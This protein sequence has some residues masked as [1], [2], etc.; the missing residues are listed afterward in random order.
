MSGHSDVTQFD[1]DLQ[2]AIAASHAGHH[3][4][5]RCLFD[6][7]LGALADDQIDL[8]EGRLVEEVLTV[9]LSDAVSRAVLAVYRTTPLGLRAEAVLATMQR[10]QELSSLAPAPLRLL[11]ETSPEPLPD[12]DR[13]LRLWIARLER[14]PLAADAWR[15]PCEA[16]LHEA[17]AYERGISGLAE[18]ARSTQRSTAFQSW[19]ALAIEA[20][21]WRTVLRIDEEAIASLSDPRECAVLADHAALA[22]LRLGH[23]DIATRLQVAFERDPDLPRAL[24]W[25]AAEVDGRPP[26]RRI[27]QARAQRALLH[28]PDHAAALRNLLLVVAGDLAAARSHLMP[29]PK[30]HHAREEAGPSG[31]GARLAAPA[32]AGSWDEPSGH[33]LFA[34]FTWLLGGAPERSVRSEVVA[35]WASSRMEQLSLRGLGAGPGSR[36]G[37]PT[38]SVI[39]VLRLSPVPAAMTP[40][41][42]RDLLRALQA[43]ASARV[44]EVAG[45]QRRR[46]YP[47]VA[48]WVATLL[49]LGVV[50]EDAEATRSWLRDIR[51][52]TAALPALEL[53]LQR[54][55]AR[56]RMRPAPDGDT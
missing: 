27:V 38:P 20:G 41:A 24:R 44:R 18:H 9:A 56:A 53:E 35:P 30:P 7:L 29:R 46:Q 10:F 3:E 11:R 25:L 21:S 31:A 1:A 5:A 17:I 42:R 15:V 47:A 6:V 51:H 32:R 34:L 19:C 26:A 36:P 4:A 55:L 48:Q 22:A 37:F 50:L 23:L 14:C 13:F 39:D 12:F 43:A 16:M 28:C 45:E 52:Q 2:Q 33:L 54:A 49:E 8:G 40:S